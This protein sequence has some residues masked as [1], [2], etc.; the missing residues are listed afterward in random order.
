MVTPVRPVLLNFLSTSYAA[1]VRGDPPSYIPPI[2]VPV[3]SIRS[4]SP[5]NETDNISGSFSGDDGS[6][7]LGYVS[8]EL[9]YDPPDPADRHDDD[10]REDPAA[11]QTP[12]RVTIP[13]SRGLVP[14]PTVRRRFRSSIKRSYKDHIVF[15]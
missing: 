4:P 3:T 14:A 7:N 13:V 8:D 15:F 2:W 1:V 6:D 9:S 11:Y 5:A 12:P 10:E